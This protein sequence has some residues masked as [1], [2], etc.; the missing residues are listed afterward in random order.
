MLFFPTDLSTSSGYG[1]RP[2]T[3]VMSPLST[4]HSQ[5]FPPSAT[6]TGAT[7]ITTSGGKQ[8]LVVRGRLT[9]DMHKSRTFNQLWTV[10]EQQRLEDLLVSH[11]PEDVEMRR[12]E[13]VANALG[14]RTAT[15][16][17]LT[18]QPHSYSGGSYLATAQLLRWV[19]LSN[20]TA[21]Q[22]GLT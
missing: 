14:N 21:A 19:L 13:K 6:V 9:K 20:R 7:A 2:T 11:P 3:P 1:S 10:D 5:P 16:V 12:W 17:G 18:R 22:V 15:Q 8:A 4:Y